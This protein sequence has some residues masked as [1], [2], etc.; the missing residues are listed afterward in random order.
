[1]DFAVEGVPTDSGVSEQPMSLEETVLGAKTRASR[2]FLE[3][4]GASIGIGLESGL[5]VVDG[6]HFDFCACSIFDGRRHFVGMSSMFPLPQQV[7]ELLGQMG[8]NE[9]FDALGVDPNP[10]GGGVLAT[11]TG[12]PST[13]CMYV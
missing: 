6:K 4:E 11:M 12:Q 8:Y 2:A 5:V 3:I 13:P 10:D 9:A 1:M 7:V